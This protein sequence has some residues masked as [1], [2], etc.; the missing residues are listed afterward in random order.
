[1]PARDWSKN[2][3]TRAV[4]AMHDGVRVSADTAAAIGSAMRDLFGRVTARAADLAR[5]DGRA[6]ILDRDVTV[7]AAEVRRG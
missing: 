4:H 5:R 1:M 2:V 6:T 7:A 3:G